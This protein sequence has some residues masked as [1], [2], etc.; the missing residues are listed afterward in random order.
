MAAYQTEDPE[1]LAGIALA[2]AETGEKGLGVDVNT[3]GACVF[4]ADF[5]G[6]RGLIVTNASL[7]SDL[8]RAVTTAL[9]RLAPE[10]ITVSEPVKAS[11]R[12]MFFREFLRNPF[13]ALYQVGWG[14]WHSCL[15]PF[16]KQN[17]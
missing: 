11:L 14:L 3:G 9:R 5:D 12:R 15:N 13:S 1:E 7:D 2:A 8:G 4:H 10:R 17:P 6:H 16:R